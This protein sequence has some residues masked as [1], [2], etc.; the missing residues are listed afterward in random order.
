MY[1]FSGEKLLD[2]EQVR[3]RLQ[4]MTDAQLRRFGSAAR[5]MCSPE[6][7]LG[8]PPRQNFVLQLRGGYRGMETPARARREVNSCGAGGRDPALK[9]V[10]PAV[11]HPQQL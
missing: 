10:G 5:Y 3:Q 7:N 8:Q 4:R 11:E 1:D 6:A 9:T 2:R